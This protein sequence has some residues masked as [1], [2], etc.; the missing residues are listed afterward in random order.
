MWLTYK[1]IESTLPTPAPAASVSAVAAKPA[2]PTHAAG[3][4]SFLLTHPV[5]AVLLGVMWL[6]A[7]LLVTPMIDANEPGL[8]PSFRTFRI[9]LTNLIYN[10]HMVGL[11]VVFIGITVLAGIVLTFGT[12]FP[13]SRKNGSG[14]SM[15]RTAMILL[16]I[17][18][19]LALVWPVVNQPCA[20][21][22]GREFPSV[23]PAQLRANEVSTK[24][25]VSERAFPQDTAN[26][27]TRSEALRGAHP[28]EHG[29]VKAKLSLP[30]PI[31]SKYQH[32]IFSSALRTSPLPPTAAGVR[33]FDAFVRFSNGQFEQPNGHGG[34][35]LQPDSTPDI[36]GMAVKV[37]LD[38]NNTRLEH[39]MA[40]SPEEVAKADTDRNTQDFVSI[41]SDFF[42]AKNAQHFAG[43]SAAVAAPDPVSAVSEWLLPS[44][45]S[46][47]AIKRSFSRFVVA[48]RAVTKIASLNMAGGQ[49]LNPRRHDYYSA[50][51]YRMV[52]QHTVLSQAAWSSCVV[53]SCC[54]YSNFRS[55]DLC[56]PQGPEQDVTARNQGD[57]LAVKYRW[58]PCD[59]ADRAPITAKGMVGLIYIKVAKAINL[60]LRVVLH[61][62]PSSTFQLP[63]PGSDSVYV[64]ESETAA[65]QPQSYLR[66]NLQNSLS[67]FDSLARPACFQLMIQ[68]Q[69]DACQNRIEEAHKPWVGE[70]TPVARL[71]IPLQLFLQTDA[72]AVCENLSFNPWHALAAHKPLGD[73]NK[74][75]KVAYIES[76]RTRLG[77]NAQKPV[78]PVFTGAELPVQT[79]PEQTEGTAAAVPQIA[80]ASVPIAPATPALLF[81]NPALY[82]YSDYPAPYERMPKKIASPPSN[83]SFSAFTESVIG[84]DLLH[85]ILAQTMMQPK[86]EG[87][88]MTKLQEYEFIGLAR[89]GEPMYENSNH[90]LSGRLRRVP[91]ADEEVWTT[92]LFWANQFVRGLNPMKVVKV[93]PKNP[94]TARLRKLDAA[95]KASVAATLRNNGEKV[96]TIEELIAAGRCLFADYPEI[97]GLMT[98]NTRILYAPVVVFYLTESKHVLMPLLI[99]LQNTRHC[100]QQPTITAAGEATVAPCTPYSPPLY[101]PAPW[102]P[103]LPTG[104]NQTSAALQWMFAKMH[105]SQSDGEVHQLISHLLET[106]LVMEATLIATHRAFSPN[107]V[108]YRMLTPHFTGTIA[109]NEFGRMT[110]VSDVNPFTDVYQSIGAVGA[111]EMMARRYL[112]EQYIYMETVPA[113]FARR[114]FSVPKNYEESVSAWNSGKLEEVD[115]FLYKDYALPLFYAMRE[116]V[117]EVLQQE[118]R[119]AA[120]KSDEEKIRAVKGQPN[121]HKRRYMHALLW[122]I[123]LFVAHAF[124]SLFARS[125]L[126]CVSRS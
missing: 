84:S 23:R 120:S 48:L 45:F 118:T 61:L 116:Y 25:I 65:G 67:P 40:L 38:A 92:D 54:S 100:D 87:D 95:Q 123:L 74:V 59:E 52:R 68:D 85:T 72:L 22:L 6:I 49:I 93:G 98:V 109:I 10:F 125:L 29:C 111:N 106:H 64:R 43:L 1:D 113:Q 79:Y 89:K 32:G 108:V 27:V 53:V 105:A 86:V 77:L 15:V 81:G 60:L 88:E 107:H 31:P 7:D 42:F 78:G 4:G 47:R 35:F 103:A 102:V 9:S 26:S 119:F 99:Q 69:R 8:N 121:T 94:M 115:G 97:D 34:W 44:E 124:V 63:I 30:Y 122:R 12:K 70:W 83:E 14:L 62:E 55:F 71:D 50:V 110:L 41:S 39:L 36:R 96:S 76:A 20:L 91:H 5:F 75:R 37:V 2:A 82:A 16:P 28:K 112:S 101:F 56:V 90:G 33:E 24:T 58:R 66:I 17:I 46:W 3:V 11:N 13:L 73:V 21:Q 104:Q 57:A 19:S 51:P 18:L 117:T 80:T 114:G 126:V